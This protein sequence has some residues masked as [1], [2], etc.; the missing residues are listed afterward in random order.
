MS[1]DRFLFLDFD[2][3]LHPTTHG[4]LLFS[5]THLLEE[6]FSKHQCNIVISSSW[7]FHFDLAAIKLLLPDVIRPYIIGVT[8]GAY[9]GK[10]P[11]YHEI[12]G[13]LHDRDKHLATWKALDDS[14]MEFPEECENLI[15][16]NP[17][18]GITDWEVKLLIDWLNN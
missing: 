1:H 7:R 3:V 18:T 9:I 8:S 16:C 5:K 11:R 17:N 13:Y 10:Y 2:G 15:R 14:W 6:V 4:A 12:I